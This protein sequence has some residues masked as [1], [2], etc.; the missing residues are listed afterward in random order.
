M[1]H[2]LRILEFGR[3]ILKFGHV[4]DFE[5]AKEFYKAIV[6]SE[7]SIQRDFSKEE[8]LEIWKKLHE[9]YKPVHNQL[10]RELKKLCE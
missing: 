1:Y 3:Q 8:C 2:S 10:V 5:K 4:V 7:E 6:N 9:K